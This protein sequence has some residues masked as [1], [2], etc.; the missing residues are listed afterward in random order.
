MDSQNRVIC[1]YRVSL[2]RQVDHVEHDGQTVADIPMQRTAC[3]KYCTEH[4]WTIIGEFQETGISGY[5][6]STFQRTAVKEIIAAANKQSFDTLLVYT[7]DRLSRRDYELPMLFEQITECGITVWSV[8]EGE[9]RYKTSTD[10]L[11]VYLYGWKANGESERISQRISTIQYQMTSRGEFRGGAVP[12]G[13]KLVENGQI[14][15]Q[16]HPRHDLAICEPEAEVVRIIFQKI[17]NEGYS[18]YEL[19][20]FLSEM[21][22]PDGARKRVWRSASLHVLLRNPIYIGRLRFNSELSLPFSRLQIVDPITFQQVQQLTKKKKQALPK[23]RPDVVPPPQYH[24][25][26]Y[27]GH[28]GSRLVYNH[29]FRARQDGTSAIR[30]LYRCYNK[31]RFIN[32]CDGAATYSAR[33]I[34]ANVHQHVEWLITVLL[35]FDE[36]ALLGNAVALART[37][38]LT[39]RDSLQKQLAELSD[40]L[41]TVQKGIA[42][43][44]NLY[45]VSATTELQLL[46]ND[47]KVKR[48]NTHYALQQLIP[49]RYAP[50]ALLKQ[51]KELL[52]KIQ[53][54]CMIWRRGNWNAVESMIP[55]FFTRILIHKDCNTRY[56][57]APEI[58]QFITVDITSDL[59]CGKRL[60]LSHLGLLE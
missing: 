20:R 36:A 29:A 41:A 27:C 8:Q 21:Q 25:I 32:P 35:T 57:I 54:K 7:V 45:G 18:M 26:L 9:L 39:Q 31:E 37:E 12:Y 44:L 6:N 55:D 3:R 51:K 13:Y 14:S 4:G 38:Y 49:E 2:L 22:Y 16:G 59:I 5:K 10:R 42:E 50:P 47:I 53:Q 40:Q 34:D 19:T 58:K 56:I 48:D 33:L 15:K 52:R 24:D 30:Y 23:S 60:P 11:L 17:A 28:C 43:A 1:L 46:Y